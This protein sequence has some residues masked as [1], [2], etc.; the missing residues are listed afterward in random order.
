MKYLVL[1]GTVI[2]GASVKAGD[3]VEVPENEVKSLLGINRI[4]PVAEKKA[5]TVN[6]SVGLDEETKPKRRTRAKKK[7]E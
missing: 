2:D 7:A 3:V 1:K 5:E 4:A 6:R